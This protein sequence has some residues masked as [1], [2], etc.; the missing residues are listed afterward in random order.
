MQSAWRVK[1]LTF[2]CTFISHPYFFFNK[3]FLHLFLFPPPPLTSPSYTQWGVRLVKGCQ[4]N[5]LILALFLALNGEGEEPL[6]L[7]GNKGA[8]E[9]TAGP[10]QSSHSIGRWH[11]YGKWCPEQSAIAEATGGQWA[12]VTKVAM[13]QLQCETQRLNDLL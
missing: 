10:Y 9:G 5:R 13:D 2:S 12:A 7:R 11:N 4:E 1:P 3:P 6:G 8:V